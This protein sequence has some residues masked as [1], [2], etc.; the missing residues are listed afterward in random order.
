MQHSSRL[1]RFRLAQFAEKNREF[2][3]TGVD[4]CANEPP[5]LLRAYW[6][7]AMKMVRVRPA[8]VEPLKNQITVF[9]VEKCAEH[10]D[11]S[12]SKTL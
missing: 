5:R 8:Q 2:P 4:E 11:R 10:N 12:V 9:T 7:S 1:R 6:A 3:E